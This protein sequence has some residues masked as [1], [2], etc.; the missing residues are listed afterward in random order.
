MVVNVL[1]F[2]EC[3]IKN[4]SNVLYIPNNGNAGD[5][6]IATATIQ[7]FHRI[8]A[9]V[10]SGLIDDITDDA[11]III[12]GGGNLVPY[13]TDVRNILLTCLDRNIKKCLLLP[14]TVRA[15][16]DVL[17]RLDARFTILC[18]DKP[19]YE[20]V[21]KH[22]PHVHAA[23]ARDMVF[24]LNIQELERN[25]KT[26]RHKL[27]LL[28]DSHW[29][30]NLLRWRR[31]TTRIRPDRQ[32]TLR[33]FRFDIESVDSDR[34]RR[35]SDLMRFHGIGKYSS[36]TDQITLDVIK[37]VN[38]AERVITDRLHVSLIAAMLGKKVCLL[39]NSY[40]TLSDVWKLEMEMGLGLNPTELLD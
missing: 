14:H 15:H 7:M 23:L 19:S 12:G 25:T 33:I 2:L 18:R 5:A 27:A 1:P 39:E 32:G 22:A 31:A 3:W 35:K 6:A 30:T 34:T 10:E 4:L 20:Y 24:E 13:Y 40:G 9:P 29:L 8:C 11:N 16:A 26:W 36:A 38:R 28:Q 21:K 17:A 37:C